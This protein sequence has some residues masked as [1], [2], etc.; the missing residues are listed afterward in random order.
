MPSTLFKTVLLNMVYAY[1][2]QVILLH[3]TYQKVLIVMKH[4]TCNSSSLLIV[5][6]HPCT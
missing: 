3:T 5:V 2:M 1:T 6:V 4:Y